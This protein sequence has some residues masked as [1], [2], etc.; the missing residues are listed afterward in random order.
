MKKREGGKN[1]TDEDWPNKEFY[2]VNIYG[3][4]S[5]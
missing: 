5:T 4:I 2:P 3:I 1:K